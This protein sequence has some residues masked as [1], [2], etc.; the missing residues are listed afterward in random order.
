MF[1]RKSFQK[2]PML[3][4]HRGS[5]AAAPENTLAAFGQALADGADAIE[6]DVHLC[7]DHEVVVIHD[8]RLER[9][10][11]GRGRVRDHSLRELKRLSAGAWFNRKF[12]LERIPTLGEVLD[13]VGGKAG[14]NIEIKT[15]HF[16]HRTFEIVER[17]LEIVHRH[18][19]SQNVL[20]SSFFRPYVRHAGDI[21]RNVARGYLYHPLRDFRMSP[22]AL[23]VA[24]GADAI[25][26]NKNSV[27]KKM[28]NGLHENRVLVGVY[29]INTRASLE[30]MM[31]MNVDLVYSNKPE[32]I[33]AILL[34]TKMKKG[35]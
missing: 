16:P 3:V 21:D 30:N 34:G 20:I 4:A 26:C 19:A 35:S 13:L 24:A 32:M 11:D 31:A 1:F 22:H 6:L 8:E 12:S 25:I 10:T 15:E 14:V 9:T 2:L 29:T 5:S 18:K 23:A 28:V 17:C 27:R 7:K 33:R